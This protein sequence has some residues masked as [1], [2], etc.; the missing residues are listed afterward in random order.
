MGGADGG[1]DG[2][3]GEDGREEGEGGGETGRRYWLVT[4]MIQQTKNRVRELTNR[5][6]TV[7]SCPSYLGLWL[8]HK[9]VARGTGL[10]LQATRHAIYGSL[11]S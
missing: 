11:G 4:T 6:T 7:T 5:H 10:S 3:D 8:L 1:G 9:D 2:E